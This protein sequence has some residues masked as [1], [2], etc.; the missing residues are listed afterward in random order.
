MRNCVTTRDLAKTWELCAAI[1][2]MTTSKLRRP[3]DT[4]RDN[5]TFKAV[6]SSANFGANTAGEGTNNSKG[7]E[8]CR[9]VDPDHL[10]LKGCLRQE[11]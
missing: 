4:A 11:L 3:Q 2:W 10:T 1:T 7:P 8:R 9:L 6:L 5:L